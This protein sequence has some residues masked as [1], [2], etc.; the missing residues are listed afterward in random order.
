M[1]HGD[2]AHLALR[3]A[4]HLNLSRCPHCSAATPTFARM[5][6]FLFAPKRVGVLNEKNKYDWHIYVCNSCG[7]VIC[8]ATV[9]DSRTN[10]PV[11]TPNAIWLIP[12]P[13]S[14]RTDLPP[15]AASY[16]DQAEEAMTSPSAAVVMCAAAVDAMLKERG[17]KV[18]SLYKRIEKAAEDNVL[19]QDMALWAHDVRL[20]AND[21]VT[22]TRMPQCL[23]WWTQG[24]ATTSPSR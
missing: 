17:Y 24:A 20:D 11:Q 3:T 15:K 14:A 21:D 22:L 16:L 18:G 13:R 4:E 2:G 23:R 1:P 19:T 8:A 6:N 12:A 7:G 5:H 10:T 9:V